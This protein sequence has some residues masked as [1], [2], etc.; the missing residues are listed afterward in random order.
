MYEIAKLELA[1]VGG[2]SFQIAMTTTPLARE[3]F[4]AMADPVVVINQ[5]M[6]YNT[7]KRT[8]LLPLLLPTFTHEEAREVVRMLEIE[9]NLNCLHS[10]IIHLLTPG[11]KSAGWTW[12]PAEVIAWIKGDTSGYALSFIFGEKVGVRR[13]KHSLTR[14][15]RDGDAD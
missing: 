10:Q 4:P 7:I 14:G 12:L 2:E 1:V 9:A 6:Y 3:N 13:Y 15:E 11:I 5:S 8:V